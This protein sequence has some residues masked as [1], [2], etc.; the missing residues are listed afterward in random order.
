MS[1]TARGLARYR[2]SRRSHRMDVVAYARI[3]SDRSGDE[4]GVSRQLADVCALAERH[5]N[6]IAAEVVHNVESA[7]LRWNPRP[8]FTRVIE[9]IKGG[10][11]RRRLHLAVRPA[12]SFAAR[13]RRPGGSG[14][15]TRPVKAN[16]PAEDADQLAI[17]A[18][19]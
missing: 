19:K 13:S 7:Y 10:E 18:T 9:M 17:N 1:L 4:A 11:S 15:S 16:H 6:R 5:G 14:R 2:L 3:S 8:G 12:L